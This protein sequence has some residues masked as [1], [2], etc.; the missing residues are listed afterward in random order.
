MNTD[1]IPVNPPSDWQPITDKG[2]LATLGKTVEELCEGIEA[3]ARCASITARCIIQGIDEAE[4]VTGKINRIA[5][6]NEIADVEAM[7]EHIKQR[8]ALDRVHITD[9]RNKKFAYKASWFKG[10]DNAQ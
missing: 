10:L 4:P 3:F 1:E 2:D 5:M 6:E 7:I 8:F 9:R